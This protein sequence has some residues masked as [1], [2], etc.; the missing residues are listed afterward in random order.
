LGEMEYLVEMWRTFSLSPDVMNI[1]LR[2]ERN[3]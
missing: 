1:H 3:L 2:Y